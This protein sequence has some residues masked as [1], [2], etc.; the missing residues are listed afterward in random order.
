MN[1]DSDYKSLSMNI[2]L[3]Y[4][5]TGELLN[6]SNDEE[7]L[8]KLYMETAMNKKVLGIALA[9]L[10]CCIAANAAIIAQDNAGDAV[11]SDG[12]TAGDNGGTG[13]GAWEMDVPA[14]GQVTI[15]DSTGL[16][17]SVDIN[18]AGGSFRVADASSYSHTW[19]DFGATLEPGETFSMQFAAGVAA[20]NKGF[21]LRTFGTNKDGGSIC[22][23]A[24][25]ASVSSGTW[26][27]NT[28][29]GQ[30]FF[31]NGPDAN[32]WFDI[33]CTQTD[34]TGGTYTVTRHGTYSETI[35]GNYTG[36]AGNFKVYA[37]TGGTADTDAIYYNNLS[38]TSVPEPATLGLLGLAFGG[39]VM[40]RRRKK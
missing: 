22:N 7:A 31:S 15:A 26:Y 21:D 32:T 12:W 8:S 18:T 6:Q 23:L 34:L 17:P 28:A 24:S 29:S 38:I 5:A 14:S 25:R 27:V 39:L 16:D 13:F 4:R 2:A 40:L 35:M 36:L 1:L 11:Y 9:S 33:A 10:T 3:N 37:A 30:Q 19:R 20:N